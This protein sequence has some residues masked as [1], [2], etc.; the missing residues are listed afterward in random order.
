MKESQTETVSLD[1]YLETFLGHFSII[2]FFMK[3][4]MNQ[5]FD[6]VREPKKEPKNRSQ[7]SKSQEAKPKPIVFK[8]AHYNLL[9]LINS[10]LEEEDAPEIDGIK[11]VELQQLKKVFMW[12]TNAEFK[13]SEHAA[14]M[15]RE[16]FDSGHLERFEPHKTYYYLSQKGKQLLEENRRK[17]KESLNKIF[18]A[19][20]KKT[21]IKIKKEDYSKIL[22]ISEQITGALWKTIISEA[23]T[24]PIPPKEA[25]NPRKPKKS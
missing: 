11:V 14:N 25:L 19:I 4:I 1:D 16:M 21:K 17:R 20:E 18:E 10:L 3:P 23:E 24:L 6:N 9:W 8:M 2:R 22:G 13:Y 15:A 5:D 7:K 12:F